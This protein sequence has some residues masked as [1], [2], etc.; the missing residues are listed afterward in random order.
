MKPLT[1]PPHPL[2][3]QLPPPPLPPNPMQTLE[4]VFPT[5]PVVNTDTC[6]VT[7]SFGSEYGAYVL[8][9]W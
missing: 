3:Y 7:Y 9:L 8:L 1:P 6:A 2:L 4:V 5:P